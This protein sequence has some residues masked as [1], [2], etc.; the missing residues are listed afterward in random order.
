MADQHW[1]AHVSAEDG[2]EQTIL[3]HLAGTAELCSQFAAAFGAGEQGRLAG[4]AHDIGK[5]SDAFQLRIRGSSQK[6]DHST[7]GAFECQRMGQP[8]AAFAVAG[9]H[10]GLPDGGSRTDHPEQSTFGGRMNR[11]AKGKLSPYDAWK[12]E[13]SLSAAPPPP[14]IVSIPDGMFFTRMLYS[15][16]VRSP[17]ARGRGLKWLPRPA[18]WPPPPRF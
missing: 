7:A 15:C 4:M 3:E 12:Q 11:A 9:H 13:I 10:G 17:P 8:F 16:L 6:V 5:Y 2:R 18:S 1:L 14:G